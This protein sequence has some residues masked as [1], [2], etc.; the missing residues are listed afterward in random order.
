MFGIRQRFRLARTRRPG[1][2]YPLIKTP[3]IAGG[4]YYVQFTLQISDTVMQNAYLLT[5]TAAVGT[6]VYVQTDSIVP[7][8]PAPITSAIALNIATQLGTALPNPSPVVFQVYNALAAGPG[9]TCILGAACDAVTGALLYTA[10]SALDPIAYTG[11]E[12]VLQSYI[13]PITSKLITGNA[14]TVMSNA[15]VG[16]PSVLCAVPANMPAPA[17]QFVLKWL[18]STAT[19]GYLVSAITL[20]TTSQGGQVAGGGGFGGGGGGSNTCQCAFV[21]ASGLVPL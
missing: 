16:T 7:P 12:F 9:S 11:F 6:P 19:Q 5:T 15:P 17:N 20:C 8:A 10:P 13:V 4:T 1:P 3:V 18:P 14:C 2:V 21:G